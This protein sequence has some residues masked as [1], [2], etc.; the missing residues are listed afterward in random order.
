VLL[1]EV[2]QEALPAL[3]QGA[4][5]FLYPTLYEGFGLPVVEAMASGVAVI[6]SNTS[7]LKEIA[8]GYAYLVDPLDVKGMGEAIALCMTDPERR[9]A[10]A[11][12]GRRRAEAFHWR[13]AAAATLAVYRQ[14]LEA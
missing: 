4:D 12:L 6:T 7:A 11:D 2:A 3:Y 5:L 1:G 8:E 9:A 14:A 13:T 10:L